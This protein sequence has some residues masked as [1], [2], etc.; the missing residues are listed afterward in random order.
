MLH[1]WTNRQPDYFLTL[2]E[3]IM[4]EKASLLLPTPQLQFANFSRRRN[5]NNNNNEN[6]CCRHTETLEISVFLLSSKDGKENLKI[7]EML[8]NPPGRG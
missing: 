5:K 6:L 1:F 4:V 3:E 2:G 7:K 8:K